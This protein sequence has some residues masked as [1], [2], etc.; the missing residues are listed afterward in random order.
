MKQPFLD[1]A[2]R[3][4]RP[5]LNW[6]QRTTDTPP[7]NPA[8]STDSRSKDNLQTFGDESWA[9]DA[10]APSVINDL[11]ETAILERRDEERW[12]EREQQQ[13]NHLPMPAGATLR[14][15]DVT[16]FLKGGAA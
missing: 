7:P 1:S 3:A 15:H 8:T 6:E 11:I 9:L 13:N 4:E 5:A 14:R 16:A 2:F 12:E 10:P